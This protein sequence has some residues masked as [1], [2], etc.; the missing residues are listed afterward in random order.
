MKSFLK[1][2]LLG[3]LVTQSFAFAKADPIA[4]LVNQL[5]PYVYGISVNKN[6][7]GKSAEAMLTYLAL[8]VNRVDKS[9]FKL[10]N[11]PKSAP[12]VEETSGQYGLA[13]MADAQDYLET[14]Y[15]D[16]EGTGA[17]LTKDQLKEI[18]DTLRALKGEGVLYGYTSDGAG[19]CGVTYPSPLIIDKENHRIFELLL[20]GGSC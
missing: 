2:S 18:K 5:K 11:Y 6:V 20:V 15:N 7:E 14:N 10:E 8:E 19:V 3:M 9:D 16:P 1:L 12:G 13:T 17:T 4:K